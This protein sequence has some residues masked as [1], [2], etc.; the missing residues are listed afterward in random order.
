MF[1]NYV[2]SWNIN[3]DLII[4][5]AQNVFNGSSNILVSF[6]V[7]LSFLLFIFSTVPKNVK[8]YV[9]ICFL[10]FAVPKCFLYLVF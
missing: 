3:L 4:S 9:I 8:I 5:I 10:V 7:F 6:Y 1:N 2:Y